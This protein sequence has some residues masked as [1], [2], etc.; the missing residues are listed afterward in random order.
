[1]NKL[2]ENFTLQEL[3]HSITAK[4]RGIDNTPNAVVIFKMRALAKNV[5]Q[6]ARDFLGA[7]ITVSSG[8]RS[9][10]LNKAIG[11]AK[12]SQ[13]RLGEAADIVCENNKLVFDYIYDN[14]EFDQLIW[15]FGDDLQP[16]WIHVSFTND[17][18]RG[19]VLRALKKGRKTVYQLF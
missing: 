1:M 2:T 9:P 7:P 10:K 5:L 17:G 19:E 16:D 18:N 6:P 8:Y 13:H 4:N 3:T 12:Y 14:L 15:E 11:G